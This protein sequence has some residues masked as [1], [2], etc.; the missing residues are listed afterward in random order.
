MIGIPF[1]V[2]KPKKNYV[3]GW[4]IDCSNAKE[5]QC[6]WELTVMD[7][8]QHPVTLSFD[9]VNGSSPL[10][11]GLDVKQHADTCNRKYPRTI[12]F[13]RPGD[14][15]VYTMHTYIEKDT[16]GSDRSRLQIVPHELSPIRTMMTTTDER[17]EIKMAKQVHKFGHAGVSDMIKMMKPSGYDG[18]RIK[19]ACIKVHQACAICAASG[20][21]AN[22]KKLST[23]HI[24]AA[25]NEEIQADF[26]YVYIREKKY[27]V[28]NII[29]LGTKYG[30]RIISQSRTAEKMK[31]TFETK[32]FYNHGAPRRF[33]ADQEFCRP[34]LHRFLS[35]HNIL[36][37]PRPSRS[38]HKTG[39]VERNN[40]VLKTVLERLQKAD[41][42]APPE[43]LLARAS[44]LTNLIRGSRVMNAFQ[45]VRGY[46]P[47]IL[48]IPR[49]TVSQ[50]LIDA[51]ID[52]EST[53]ALE[54]MM[55]LK[56]PK[57]I[58]TT[59]LQP[60]TK[61]LVYYK[62]SK[63][64][65]QNEWI[66]ATIQEV[67]E[68]VITCRK[69]MKGPP[70]KV[71]HGDVRLLPTGQLTR[72]LM[73]DEMNDDNN[74]TILTNSTNNLLTNNPSHNH[75]NITN[76]TNSSYEDTETTETA[77]KKIIIDTGRIDE[78]VDHEANKKIIIDT[79][80]INENVDHDAIDKN[81]AH[82]APHQTKQ[83]TQIGSLQA[84]THGKEKPNKDIGNT[85]I[86]M[87]AVIGDLT[88]NEQK[89]L[90][91]LHNK[92]GNSTVTLNKLQGIPPWVTYKAITNEHD[93][94]WTDAYYEVEEN[95]IPPNANVITSH[96]IYKVKTDEQGKHTMKARICPHGN[97]DTMKD[98][99]R[100]DSATAQ[101]DAIRLLL[102]LTTFLSFRLG[103]ADISGAYMQSGP[104]KRDIYVRP[105]RE[106]APKSRGS[107]WKLLKLPY[108]VSEAGRQWANVIEEWLTDEM[109]F[110]QVRGISQ[111]FLKRAEDGSISMLL[112][113][114]T[115]DLLISG[116]TDVLKNFLQQLTKKFKVSKSI[117]DS[118]IDFNGCRIT[119]DEEGNIT[120]DMK[121]YVDS[122]QSLDITRSR[123]KEA[124]D[125]ATE[126]EY[127]D[128]R[129]LAG[130]LMWAGNGALPQ[131][132]F[133]ASSMQQTAPRLKLHN[134]TEANKM[135]KELKD[136]QPI[137]RFNKIN[138]TIKEIDIWTFSDASFNITSG[139]DYGQT[140]IITGIHA[141]GDGDNEIYHAIDW[142]SSKQRRVSHSSYGAE[143]LACADADDRGYYIKQAVKSITK[144]KETKHVLHV[145]SRGLFDTISTL[146]DGK[147]YRLRQTVQRIRDSFESHDIDIL[148]WIPTGENLAD[149]LTKRCPQ[150][151]RKFNRVCSQGSLSLNED[152]MKQLDS[153]EW[154]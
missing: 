30:E 18:Q 87:E 111:L 92:I 144:N 11:I 24:N 21:P 77:N 97:K 149:S 141:K 47:S 86:R 126:K 143:I 113:K 48:G 31:E 129:S 151:Q 121:K 10:I 133:V 138:A 112:A 110:E 108:G 73:N 152:I 103:A 146:H 39:R 72:E 148:R 131:A 107:I 50:E 130:S 135:L 117:L 33:S 102:S 136:L 142:A 84:V 1:K 5:I 52:R 19:E 101:Y 78:N 26:L 95:S 94:N 69:K 68:H 76:T 6:T 16:T 61:V 128:Y 45:M 140:G 120:M 147:E 89:I 17:Q 14:I 91:N 42:A 29:D 100:K 28:L 98:D 8:N 137:I 82:D 22:R 106:W 12:T 57:Q 85:E 43:A 41:T 59:L 145:D 34:V 105:P 32:W 125:K 27:E 60:G 53:R 150:T 122:I 63:Q 55:K 65:E 123:R 4:G 75:P 124:N 36:L 104:I 114:V 67:D 15:H 13:Q 153:R 154:Q 35:K 109:V 38:S 54:R 23:T 7:V 64:N 118:Q 116:K 139:R 37:N 3:H 90:T 40:G 80:R 93:N 127:D 71:S 56:S 96:V 58:D 44:F 62:S 2:F 20:R 70:M 119:Q 9:L 49:E 81:V 88:S 99:I 51:H 134:L 79:G 25:F 83:C 66:E 46:S 74:D 132:S 115:D